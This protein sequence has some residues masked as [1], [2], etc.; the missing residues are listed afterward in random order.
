MNSSV[1]MDSLKD[2]V[3]R[4]LRLPKKTLD[5]EIVVFGL[6]SSIRWYV[7]VSK[8]PFVFGMEPRNGYKGP[9]HVFVGFSKNNIFPCSK[10]VDLRLHRRSHI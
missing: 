3:K 2:S 5:L 4:F 6:K 9:S 7:V 8:M 1:L 10:F